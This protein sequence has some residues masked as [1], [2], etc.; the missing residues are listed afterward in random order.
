MAK[1]TSNLSN[2]IEVGF[3]IP[4]YIFIKLHVSSTKYNLL[5]VVLLKINNNNKILENIDA[6]AIKLSQFSEPININDS[7]LKHRNYINK[8]RF[9]AKYD[10]KLTLGIINEINNLT[11]YSIAYENLIEEI[12]KAQ[13]Q[14]QL[15]NIGDI[16]KPYFSRVMFDKGILIEVNTELVLKQD[17]DD[18][19]L[20]EENKPHHEFSSS[21]NLGTHGDDFF[22]VSNGTL[23]SCAPVVAPVNGTPIFN[24]RVGDQ[25]MVKLLKSNAYEEKLKNLFKIITS[26]SDSPYVPAKIVKIRKEENEYSIL[27]KIENKV[28]GK[29]FETEQI[30]IKTQQ[31]KD[32]DN[33]NDNSNKRK[34]DTWWLPISTISLVIIVILIVLTYIFLF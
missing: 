20:R 34:K 30:K 13:R 19:N 29:I 2:D 31:N 5:S 26:N 17:I 11:N 16:L 15:S 9:S 3:D 27:V 25:I 14:K 18:S 28:F 6:V 4:S 21:P 12:L 8:K 33:F 10:N 7:W 1:N 32:T 24:L 23:F 22:N